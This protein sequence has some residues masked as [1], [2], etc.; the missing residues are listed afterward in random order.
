[1]QTLTVNIDIQPDILISLNQ[2]KVDFAKQLKL[3]AAISMFQHGK[4]S[5]ARAANLADLHRYDFENILAELKIP[6]SN[7]NIEDA[8]KELELLKNL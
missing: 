8:K 1:M 6:I 2:N 4:L 5:L 3:W 7:I